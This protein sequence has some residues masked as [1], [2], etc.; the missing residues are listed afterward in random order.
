MDL[1]EATEELVKVLTESQDL[2][3]QL[4]AQAA[5]ART[6]RSAMRDK[7][8]WAEQVYIDTRKRELEENPGEDVPGLHTV[9]A[10]VHGR[11]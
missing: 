7:I 10:T 4:D 9:I 6:K 1:T 11:D 3:E 8:E 2:N 5:E